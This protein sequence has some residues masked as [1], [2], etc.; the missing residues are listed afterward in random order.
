MSEANDD[1]TDQPKS[2]RGTPAAPPR[3]GDAPPEPPKSRAWLYVLGCGLGTLLLCC[4]LSVVG[5]GGG[6]VAVQK[7]REAAARLSS[8]N[9]L[10]QMGIAMHNIAAN[11][12]KN[13]NIPPSNGNFPPQVGRNASFFFHLVPYLEGGGVYT[14]DTPNTPIKTYIAP[15]DPRNPRTNSTI[16]YATN[17]TVLAPRGDMPCPRIPG[18]FNGRVSTLICVMERSGLDGAHKW[19]NVNNSLGT[20]TSPPPPPQFDADPAAYQ[21]GSPQA[22]NSAGCMVLLGDGSARPV[23][24][25]AVPVWKSLCDPAASAPPPEW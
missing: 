20:P 17:G 23:A 24:K 18:S 25:T 9:N 6:I 10:H 14:N 4:P 19:D 7:V 1:I 8:Q 13:G 3:E 2:G 21:D 15:G 11:D 22:F 12:P 16:S 5:V